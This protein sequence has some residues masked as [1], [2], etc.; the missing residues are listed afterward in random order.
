MI[1]SE[2]LAV[3]VAFWCSS[4]TS[5]WTWDVRLYPGVWLFVG[6]LAGSYLLAQG[7]RSR[8]GAP[9]PQRRRHT[10]QFLAGVA[11][12]WVASDWPIGLLGASYLSSAHML[13]YLLYS[14]VAAPLLLLGTP[15][16]MARRILGRLRLYR[17]GL[18]A[19][20]PLVAGVFYNLVLLVTMAPATTDTLRAYQVGSF[21]MDIVWL[22]AGFVL[23]LPIVSPLPEHR[24]LGYGAKMAYLFV[25]A[26]VV[27]VLPASFLTFSEFPLYSTY[28]LA[29]RV[30]TGLSAGADQAAAGL[31]MKI[32]SIP[33]IWGTLLVMMVRWGEA[34]GVPSDPPKRRSGPASPQSSGSI[35]A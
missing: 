13:Q 20:R 28:E 35:D 8:S 30:F 34:E 26:T 25:A 24:R 11:G 2:I 14:L 32:G 21:A 22:L 3:D 27:P 1:G 19:A 9:N 5:N 31:V 4:I 23:W 6:L 7:R 17:A 12:F 33:I 29:P 10:A 18:V 15:E 16:W